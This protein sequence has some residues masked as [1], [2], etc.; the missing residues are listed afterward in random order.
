MV[1]CNSMVFWRVPSLDICMN[2]MYHCA[3]REAENKKNYLFV[4]FF[5]SNLH[6]I[7][8][9]LEV[10]LCGIYMCFENNMRVCCCCCCFSFLFDDLSRYIIFI[11]LESK[12]DDAGAHSY[13]HHYIS[14]GFF[15]LAK[16]INIPHCSKK[17]DFFM[18]SSF[19]F[20]RKWH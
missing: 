18:V 8:S 20:K 17:R 14:S 6:I 2:C 9:H 16:S 5:L 3:E 19:F 4:A 13:S 1:I 11:Q 10:V 7:Y 12:E 15:S